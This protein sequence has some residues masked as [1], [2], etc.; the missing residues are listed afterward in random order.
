MNEVERITNAYRDLEAG[1]TARW[2]AR[3]TG[4]RLMVA[5]R[6][7]LARRLL[8]DHRWVPLGERR[9]LDVGSGMGAELA[10]FRDLGAQ[11]S[12]LVG[13]DLIP[14]R[15]ER[16]RHDYPDLEFHAGNAERLPFPD[17]SFDIVLAYTVFSSILDSRMAANV[18]HEIVRVM[19]PGGGLLWYDFRYDSP[20]NQ[21]V[22]GVGAARVHELFPELHGPLMRVTLLP[23]LARRLGRVTAIAYPGL[24]LLPPLRSHLCGLL[25]KPQN[26]L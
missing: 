8:E 14:A 20:S 23:P 4:N 6:K 2:D 12:H 13:I 17:R 21:N 18:A 1:D 16:A 26:A 22:R 3:N 10:W 5:E 11:P 24:A 15:V 25:L 7:R 9:V 19:A